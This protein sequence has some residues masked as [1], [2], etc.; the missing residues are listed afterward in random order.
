MLYSG[1]VMTTLYCRLTAGMAYNTL[2]PV[3]RG[4]R[5]ID[6]NLFVG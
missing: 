4:K 5:N 3:I 2:I 6:S 1:L